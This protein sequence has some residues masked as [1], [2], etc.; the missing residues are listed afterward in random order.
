M[1]RGSRK[2]PEGLGAQCNE[3]PQDGRLQMAAQ[4]LD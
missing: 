3:G 4:G 1:N 2:E